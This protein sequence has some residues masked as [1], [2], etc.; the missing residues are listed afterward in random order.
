M[1]VSLAADQE[2]RTLRKL[3]A[4]LEAEPVRLDA[5]AR[6]AG[7]GV[8]GPSDWHLEYQADTWWLVERNRNAG[9]D[10]TG[11][12]QFVTQHPPGHT[13]GDCTAGDP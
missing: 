11:V 3:V 4:I 13:C 9:Y 5:L 8:D 6:Q 7:I 10:L 2:L 12:A 1:L